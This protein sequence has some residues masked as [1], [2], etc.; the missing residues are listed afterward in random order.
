ME[1]LADCG[2]ASGADDS[3]AASADR[4]PRRSIW[5]LPLAPWTLQQTIEEV[6]RLV[7]ARRPS[8]F[9]TANLHYAALTHSDSSLREVN[10]RAA[11]VVADGMPLI[12]ASR[13][14]NPPLPERVA[15]ADLIYELSALAARKGYRVYFLGGAEGVAAEAARHLAAR[16]PGLQVAGI[17]CPPFRALSAAEQ[18]ALL[19]RV[20]ATRP[21]LLITAF[22][23]PRGEQWLA[24]Q[25]QALAV[26]A[27][28]NLGAAIDFA[29][30]R[31]RRA[32][33][34]MQRTGLEW[35]FRL[36][37]EP[38]R[39]SRRYLD[40]GLFLMGRLLRGHIEDGKSP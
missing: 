25:I 34:W 10:R 36:W 27:A 24:A 18:D 28:V 5:G 1:Q 12:W 15:G 19:S 37:L 40:D 9:I 22:T 6:D 3:C 13:F 17:E 23:M 30:G 4:S 38:K 21:D 29:A 8:F 14:R 7:E 16:C 20:R 31:I 11:F 39:L 2:A 33:H 32:P 26:P 35:L